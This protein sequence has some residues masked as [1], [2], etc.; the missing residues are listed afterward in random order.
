MKRD[1]S[2]T[3]P[4][5]S[6]YSEGVFIIDNTRKGSVRVKRSVDCKDDGKTFLVDV[7]VSPEMRGQGIAT[8]LIEAAKEYCKKKKV[9]ELYL[10][11]DN[12]MIPFYEKRGFE[13]VHEMVQGVD[14]NPYYTM[15]CRLSK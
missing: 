6:W 11:C 14:G 9:E 4:F 2:I 10:Y 12:G 5:T 1:Y 13:N 7:F 3:R 15:K 8:K